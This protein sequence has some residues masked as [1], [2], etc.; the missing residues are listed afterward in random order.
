MSGVT[1]AQVNGHEVSCGTDSSGATLYLQVSTLS[2]DQPV[3]GGEVAGLQIG[4]AVLGVL[5]IAW[6]VRAIREFL[7]S[8]GEA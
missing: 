7:N 8:T 5:A 3:Q 6:C 1:Y 4:G 2:S